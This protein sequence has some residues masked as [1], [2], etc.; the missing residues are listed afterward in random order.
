MTKQTAAATTE[1]GGADKKRRAFWVDPRFMIGLAL[2]AVSS[3]GVVALVAASDTSVEVMAARG[4]LVPGDRVT[5]DDLVPVSVSTG[6][7]LSLYLLPDDLP[8]DGV[9]VTRSVAAGELLP[10]SAVGSVA[11]LELTSVV[12]SLDSQLPASIGPGSRVDVW[13]AR[14]IENSSYGA[15]VVLVPSAIVVR[16]VEDEGIVVGAA[17]AAVEVLIPRFSTARVLEAIVNGASLAVVP[18]DLGLRG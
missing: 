13:S 14:E 8:D 4:A 5:V 12:L 15:P 10:A 2:V 17:G 9:V 7:T 11:G 16:L 1:T 18:V 6:E 3:V